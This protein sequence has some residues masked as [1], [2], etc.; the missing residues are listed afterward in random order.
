MFSRKKRP[1]LQKNE[2]CF[3]CKDT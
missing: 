2:P 1:A 3:L